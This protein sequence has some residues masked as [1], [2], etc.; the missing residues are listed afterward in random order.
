MEPRD[1]EILRHMGLYYITLR[2]TLERLF[3]GGNKTA[4]GN[5]ITR[6][7]K[8][9]RMVTRARAF[10]SGISYYQ[11]AESEARKLGIPEYRAK[12]PAGQSLPEKLAVLWFCCMNGQA[13]KRIEKAKIEEIFAGTSFPGQHCYELDQDFQEYHIYRVFPPSA[14]DEYLIRQA[15]EH[16][17]TVIERGGY[18][19]LKT[20]AYGLALL[21][22]TPTRREHLIR[23]LRER[24]FGEK[25]NCLVEVVP[26]SD[27]L[28][29]FIDAATKNEIA[30]V[31]Y[32]R[33]GERAA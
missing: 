25:Y 19:W 30:G 17:D 3:F 33:A 8:Q 20:G 16:V 15:R 29:E 23:Q 14:D 28:K 18:E 31:G 13:R 22:E 11:L 7:T 12:A 4:C 24:G 5:V 9:K 32:N 2:V 6:L 27:T 26:T 1:L 21:A 10:P